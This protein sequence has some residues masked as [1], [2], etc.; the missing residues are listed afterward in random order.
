MRTGA[1]GRQAR[2]AWNTRVTPVPAPD[3]SGATVATLEQDSLRFEGAWR[4]IL[5]LHAQVKRRKIESKRDARE[6][7]KLEAIGGMRNPSRAV[8]RLP[9]LRLAGA[10]IRLVLEK[11]IDLHPEIVE[12]VRD[13]T[14]SAWKNFEAEHGEEL[15]STLAEAM[16]GA[17]TATSLRDG[18]ALARDGLGDG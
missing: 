12:G 6:A 14:G 17:S 5:P 16:G 9:R 1:V 13:T 18:M 7:E 10:K 2:Q 15:R 11:F 4:G 8:R 3:R